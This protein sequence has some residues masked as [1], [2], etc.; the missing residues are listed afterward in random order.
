MSSGVGKILF[1]QL[2]TVGELSSSL[3]DW[4]AHL[5]GWGTGVLTRGISLDNHFER[6]LKKISVIFKMWY[7]VFP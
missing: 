3:S 5:L 6:F 7:I 4:T 1:L 2:F